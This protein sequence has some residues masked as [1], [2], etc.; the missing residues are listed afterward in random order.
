MRLMS[1]DARYQ[2]GALFIKSNQTKFIN[3]EAKKHR[4]LLLC[5]HGLMKEI[6]NVEWEPLVHEVVSSRH[7]MADYENH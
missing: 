3:P 6:V 2:R 4:L 5:Q 1:M 7:F